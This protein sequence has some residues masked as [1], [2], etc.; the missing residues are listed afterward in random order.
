[1]KETLKK[2]VKEEGAIEV[3]QVYYD[4][5][6]ELANERAQE[7]FYASPKA[8]RHIAGLLVGIIRTEYG[9]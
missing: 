9:G 2:L 6:L 8:L 7:G 4:A 1:M 5:L 3:L